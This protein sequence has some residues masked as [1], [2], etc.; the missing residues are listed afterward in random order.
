M[1]NDH[2]IGLC[3]RSL[4]FAQRRMIRKEMGE[5][6]RM[7]EYAEIMTLVILLLLLLEEMCVDSECFASRCNS[8]RIG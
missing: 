5:R 1:V 7:R 4:A 2:C 3:P 6:M 8:I